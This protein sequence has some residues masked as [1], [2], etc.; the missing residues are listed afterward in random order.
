[1]QPHEHADRNVESFGLD[2]F[3]FDLG[4]VAISMTGRMKNDALLTAPSRSRLRAQ[5]QMAIKRPQ[6]PKLTPFHELSK[7][8][9][10]TRLRRRA[11]VRHILIGAGPGRVGSTNLAYNMAKLGARVSHERKNTREV[12]H[13]M[14]GGLVDS[15]S[16]MQKSKDH[17]EQVAKKLL[18]QIVDTAGQCSVV[19]DI[20]HTNSQLMSEF[21]GLDQRVQLVVQVRQPASFAESFM[22]L[23]KKPERW[24]TNLMHGRNLSATVEPNRR[25]RLEKYAKSIE[26]EARALKKKYPNR[27][28]VID[29]SKLTQLGPKLARKLGLPKKAWDAKG[30]RNARQKYGMGRLVKKL[31]AKAK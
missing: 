16:L 28:T 12:D 11:Q 22:S 4:E 27:V 25:R 9:K 6:G 3:G 14:A 31:D 29:V 7:E 8:G 30:G 10:K 20:S 1:M 18:D 19:G 21:L 17:K 24:E 13:A 2:R 23:M 26:S 15:F 5:G